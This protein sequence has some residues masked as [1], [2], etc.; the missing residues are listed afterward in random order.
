MQ[1]KQSKI[2]VIGAGL[3]G[4]TMAYRLQ[5]KGYDVEVYEARCRVGGRV[6][7][8]WQNNTEGGFSVGELGAQNIT[9]GGEAKHM[10]ALAKEFDLEIKDYDIEFTRVFYDGYKNYDVHDLLKKQKFNPEQVKEKL[11]QLAKTSRSMKEVLDK[12][13]PQNSILK[14]ILNFQITAYEGSK[15]EFLGTS[16]VT[17]LEYGMLGGIAAALQATGYKPLLHLA[18]LKDGNAALPIKL[19]QL[20]HNSVRFNKMLKKVQ[21]IQNKKIQ[22]HFAD[23]EK[24][25]ADKLIL[26]LPCSLYQSIDFDSMVLPV[27]RLHKF[28]NVQYGTNAK[29]FIAIASQNKKYNTVFTDH[30]SAFLNSDKQLLS[31]YF[32]GDAGNGLMQNLSKYYNDALQAI[33]TNFTIPG[34]MEKLPQTVKD[35]NFGYYNGPLVKSWVDDPYAKGSYS[36]FGLDINQLMSK[37]SKY[38]NITVRTLF[39]PINKQVFFIGEHASIIDE[40]GT[41]EAAIESAERIAKLF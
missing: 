35:E 9:D 11:K 37:Q 23:G 29:I 30:L 15:A 20:L 40:I 33:K 4:L 18:T 32:S 10:R 19:S 6:H 13:F 2:I 26:A 38:Q 22:L 39:E 5:Q 28:Q 12:L 31:L 34:S 14:R 7:S 8:I 24:K 25:I 3:A 17:T 21:L 41:M 27:D 36:C 1:N 16:Y